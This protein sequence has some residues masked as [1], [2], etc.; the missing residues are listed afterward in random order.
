MHIRELTLKNFRNYESLK[1]VFSPGINFITGFNG[2]GKTNILEAISITSSIKSFRNISDAELIKWGCDA[3]FCSSLIENSEYSRFDAG[4]VIN[5]DQGSHLKKRLKIDGNQI[6]KASEYYGKFLTVIFAPVDINIINGAPE[7]RRKFFDSVLSKIDVEYMDTLNEFKKILVSRN[8][9]LKL[10]REKHFSDI[11]QLDI[12]DSLF[13]EKASSILKKRIDFIEKYQTEFESS[14]SEIATDKDAPVINYIIS[15]KTSEK[16]EIIYN[17]LKRRQED[18]RRGTTSAGPQRD[19]YV[20]SSRS[21]KLFSNYASQGQR[22]TASISLKISEK[23]IIEEK[24]GK[25]TVIL[26]DDIFS[27]LDEKR[28]KN[29]VDIL[30]KG[31]QVIFTMVNS[32]SINMEKFG[33][34]S[35]YHIDKGPVIKKIK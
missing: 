2:T 27:E 18:I 15:T 24:T 29:M 17:L 3:Y 25:K 16:N 23:K 32:D 21:G 33:E 9:I 28:R 11:S 34:Y 12:W 30:K 5:T 31:N 1:L 4:C 22:R 35:L 7:I 10:I 14:Y 13:A 8:R 19:D 20:L 26:V 6:K